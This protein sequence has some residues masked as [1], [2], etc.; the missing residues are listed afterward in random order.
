[1]V[2]NRTDDL[3]NLHKGMCSQPRLDF[4]RL[5]I[6]EAHPGF[7]V[8]TMLSRHSTAGRVLLLALSSRRSGLLLI[9]SF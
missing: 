8:S 4:G 1:M 3:G 6:H 9:P 7:S 2:F 5:K